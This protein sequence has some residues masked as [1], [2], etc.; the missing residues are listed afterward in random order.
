[1]ASESVQGSD[2]AEC[3]LLKCPV[4]IIMMFNE[5]L[6]DDN[7]S[8]AAF[9]GACRATNA[10]LEDDIFRRNVRERDASCMVWA[11]TNGHLATMKKAIAAGG[12]PYKSYENLF[13]HGPRLPR[14]PL[15]HF[16]LANGHEDVATFLI[17]Q[18]VEF[19]EDAGRHFS[20]LVRF[21]WPLSTWHKAEHK[22]YGKAPDVEFSTYYWGWTPLQIAIGKR[23]L[24]VAKLLFNSGALHETIRGYHDRFRTEMAIRRA[25]LLNQQTLIAH[26]VSDVYPG[27]LQ[28]KLRPLK[29]ARFMNQ[30]YQ[31]LKYSAL[32]FAVQ[33]DENIEATRVLMGLGMDAHEAEIDGYTP[34]EHAAYLENWKVALAIIRDSLPAREKEPYVQLMHRS[35]R[36]RI[37][38]PIQTTLNAILIRLEEESI[39]LPSD[40]W[41][42]DAFAVLEAFA[43]RCGKYAVDR[44]YIA[45][46][47][48]KVW[49][50]LDI[51]A[52]SP[53]VYRERGVRQIKVP[54]LKFAAYYCRKSSHAIDL[55]RLLLDLGV[56]A[57]APAWGEYEGAHKT[58]LQY[59]VEALEINHFLDYDT[60][61]EEE[62][63]ACLERTSD[64]IRLGHIEKRIFEA[65]DLLLRHGASPQRIAH[66]RM[67]SNGHGI[68][69]LELALGR[70]NLREHV[71]AD[72]KDARVG[73]VTL[74]LA[75]LFLKHAGPSNLEPATI[76]ALE[77]RV[78]DIFGILRRR[79]PVTNLT[80]RDVVWTGPMITKDET[81]EY[82]EEPTG[83]RIRTLKMD[84][85]RPIACVRGWQ[86][87]RRVP[88]YNPFSSLS[89]KY[90]PCFM[91]RLPVL[92]LPWYG[93]VDDEPLLDEE[94]LELRAFRAE[95]YG[96]LK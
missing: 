79:P 89:S 31:P 46:S 77:G 62:V 47:A 92:A 49:N 75:R 61:D 48:W 1:M 67:G 8:R 14:L 23:M 65:I 26:I 29:K 69:I 21:E 10:I 59:L 3:Y 88:S 70:F 7:N 73:L 93:H 80:I 32:F 6:G 58:A 35:R 40:T 19:H 50:H 43:T 57:D 68:S 22:V 52:W 85:L 96:Y 39:T 25:A 20:Q 27:T 82:Y 53:W 11:A 71:Y 56:R 60:Q 55:M 18:G 17:Q 87:P 84:Q 5:A 16:A 2:S 38:A 12:D 64:Q 78:A 37:L 41:L 33:S 66:D 74:K 86:K 4:E 13:L 28:S 36:E 15:L 76:H 44:L 54:P 81:A 95:W 83:G 51:G 42:N 63:Y 24:S 9:R 30:K 94:E 45:D 72:H 90:P 34:L 91:A